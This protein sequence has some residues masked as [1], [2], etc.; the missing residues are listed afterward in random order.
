MVAP[1]SVTRPSS[2]AGSRASCWALLK[3]WISSRKKIVSVPLARRRC[4]ARSST[5]RTSAR[6]AC[7]ALSSSKTACEP[8]GD[9]ARERRLARSRAARRGS[10]SGACRARS[11]CAAPSPRRAG[12][13][14]RRTSSSSRGRTRAASGRAPR[15]SWR[16]SGGP[17]RVCKGCPCAPCGKRLGVAGSAPG[18]V[19]HRAVTLIE[20]ALPPA[21]RLWRA[22]RGWGIDLHRWPRQ[23]TLVRGWRRGA[24]RNDHRAPPTSSSPVRRVA[25]DLL[26]PGRRAG[27]GAGGE[28]R[29][30]RRYSCSGGAFAATAWRWSRWSSSCCWW[31]SRSPRRW[32]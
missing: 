23:G 24:V 15:P 20:T 31:S 22:A 5:A 10:S 19:E 3:R 6:P 25:V 14:A 1:I 12:G 13:P 21:G 11:R 17:R 8:L 18:D 9:H 7:T 28:W 32:S 4:S 29:R 30:A 26:D 2:T 27:A 16:R